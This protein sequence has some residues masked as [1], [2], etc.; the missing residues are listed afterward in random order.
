MHRNNGPARTGRVRG[1]PIAGKE[2]VGGEGLEAL[3]TLFLIYQLLKRIVV[4]TVM[5]PIVPAIVLKLLPK[6]CIAQRPVSVSADNTV[7]VLGH[8]E[9]SLTVAICQRSIRPKIKKSH[10]RIGRT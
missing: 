5:P 3:V 4:P 10:N 2:L 6:P 9:R 7:V 1:T 8:L